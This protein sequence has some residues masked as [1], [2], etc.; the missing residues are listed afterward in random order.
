MVTNAQE[1]IT[2]IQAKAYEEGWNALAKRIMAAISSGA[3]IAKTGKSATLTGLPFRPGSAAASIY[4]YIKKNPGMR[5]AEVIKA[6]GTEDK[7]TRTTLH[8]MKTRGYAVNE[9]GRWRVL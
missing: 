6:V 7:S 2:E 4:E 8:R 1:I 9:G 3:P 5:A